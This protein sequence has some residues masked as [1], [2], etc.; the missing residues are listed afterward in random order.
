M[1]TAAV[2]TMS[3]GSC[4]TDSRTF[5]E[6]RRVGRRS[7]LGLAVRNTDLKAAAL[8]AG[9]GGG[10]GDAHGGRLVTARR[11]RRRGAGYG[12][13][14]P[15]TPR[16]RR[17]AFKSS[18]R[19][20]SR[21]RDDAKIWT[22]SR[23]ASAGRSNGST[24]IFGPSTRA[25]SATTVTSSRRT[26]HGRRSSTRRSRSSPCRVENTNVRSLAISLG[27]KRKALLLCLD[28][29]N[30]LQAAIAS[31]PIAGVDYG[32]PARPR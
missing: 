26:R 24:P 21:R 1:Q 17:G 6:L 22:P 4:S 13:R 28:A 14:P 5:A 18:C 30:A 29:L 15:S 3:I 11:R 20:T 2:R 12:A 10:R 8:A 19:R 31:E 32:E 25:A 27:E 23:R 9:S 16:S 7:L